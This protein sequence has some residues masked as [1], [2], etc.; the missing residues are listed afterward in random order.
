[1]KEDARP[2]WLRPYIYNKNFA[3]KIKDKEID[4]LLNGG[5]IYEIKHTQWV[6]LVV[7]VSTKNGK[8]RVC[9]NLKKVNEAPPSDRITYYQVQN[10]F[11]NELRATKLIASWMD[12]WGIARYP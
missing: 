12:V 2:I 6:S 9:V 7:V 1:M 10:M 8:L 5:F 4:W 3:K 11:L